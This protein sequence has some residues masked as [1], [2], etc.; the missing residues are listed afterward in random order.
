MVLDDVSVIKKLFFFYHHY[1][2]MEANPKLKI[3]NQ[4]IVY[5]ITWRIHVS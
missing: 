5:Q 4:K 2:L 3:K 1:F